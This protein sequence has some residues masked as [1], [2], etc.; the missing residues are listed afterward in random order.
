MKK[1]SLPL[2]KVYQLLE[3]GPV[4]MVTTSAK[5]KPNIMTMTWLTMVDFVPPIIA[6]VMSEDNYSFKA[7]KE[8]K[9]CV[10]NIPTADLVKIAVGI[11]ECSGSKVDKFKKFKLTPEKASLVKA[12]MIGECFANLECKVIDMKMAA[13]YN[14]FILE[15]VKAWITTAKKRQL[16]LHHCGNGLFTVDGKQIK[17][18]FSKK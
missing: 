1:K 5:G 10:I 11:G 16:T 14:I 4:I 8:T 13:K 2:S 3:P 17:L 15:V 9:E 18:A 6:C 7:L 12:P